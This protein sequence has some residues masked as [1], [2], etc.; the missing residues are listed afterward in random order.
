M[1]DPASTAFTFLVAA[2]AGVVLELLGKAGSGL[3]VFSGWYTPA[4]ARLTCP[5]QSQTIPGLVLLYGDDEGD[6]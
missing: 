6:G 2:E 5:F 1:P 3:I 4:L